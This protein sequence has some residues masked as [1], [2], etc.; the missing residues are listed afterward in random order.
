MLTTLVF[1]ITV[2]FLASGCE[3]ITP[4]SR[5]NTSDITSLQHEVFVKTNKQ[6]FNRDEVIIVT[7]TNALDTTIATINQHAFCSIINIEKQEA[8]EWNE[9]INCTS[10]SPPVTVKIDS[11][12]VTSVQLPGLSSAGTYR[13]LLKFSPGETFHFGEVYSALSLPFTVQ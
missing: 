6:E 9:L 3:N 13:A 5:N 2:S 12:A 10:N 7:V 1:V 8:N 4:V 11:D